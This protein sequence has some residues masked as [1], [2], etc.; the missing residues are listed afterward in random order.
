MP[1][2]CIF[3]CSK[4]LGKSHLWG[5]HLQQAIAAEQ[6]R[7]YWGITICR[8]RSASKVV[9]NSKQ[10]PSMCLKQIV[11]GAMFLKASLHG[12][13]RKPGALGGGA[14][15]LICK[16]NAFSRVLRRSIWVL[17]LLARCCLK[18]SC[19]GLRRARV[20]VDEA[21]HLQTECLYD[22]C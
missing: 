5:V 4:L 15:P 20:G 6:F 22:G 2:C 8:A 3:L 13:K 17:S 1:T 21:Q 16:Q 9:G 19:T 10:E 7:S 18:R 11:D 14:A 12:I